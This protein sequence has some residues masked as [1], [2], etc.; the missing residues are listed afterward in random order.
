[1]LILGNNRNEDLG[2][3]ESGQLVGFLNDALLPLVK[4][5]LTK[6]D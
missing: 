1:M 3:G 4:A 2:S 5:K 6:S